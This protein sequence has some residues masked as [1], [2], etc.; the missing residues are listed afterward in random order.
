[1]TE[2]DGKRTAGR[3]PSAEG[4]KD[5]RTRSGRSLRQ[6]RPNYPTSCNYRRRSREAGFDHHWVKPPA[7]AFLELILASLPTRA[8]NLE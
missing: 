6:H 3:P 1:M 4:S 8:D 5:E 7:L 2:R